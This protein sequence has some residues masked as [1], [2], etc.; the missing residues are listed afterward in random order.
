[1]ILRRIVEQ[2]RAQN[3]TAI[4]IEFVLL[5][6]GV[7]LGM[8]V[9]NWNEARL[10]RALVNG[11]LSEIADDLRA[12]LLSTETL[13]R[14][15]GLRIAAV[16][17]V[18]L[19]AFSVQLPTTLVLATTEFRAP[20]AEAYPADQLD[21]LLGAINLVRVSVRARGGYES[22]TSSGRLAL[23]GDRKLAR[24]I[25]TYYGSFDDL[26]DTNTVFRTFRNDGAR[27][28]YALGMSVFDQRPAAE[29]VALA[30]DNPGFAAY[31]RSQREWAIVHHNLLRNLA[32][33]TTTLLAAIEIELAKP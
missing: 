12:H 17:H 31:L 28:Q 15:A 11:H 21:N 16:D 7:F 27:E 10:E 26:L 4:S 32:A 1:V 24:A 6:A 20:P 2:V 14:S 23:L 33:E 29:I 25:Q 22:L 30:R 3:W 19:E 13:E 5:V 18:Y 8:Q 9:S